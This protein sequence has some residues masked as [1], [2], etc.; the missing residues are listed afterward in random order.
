[1]GWNSWNLLASQVN[2]QDLR[3]IADALVSSGMRDAGYQYLVIDDL[4]QTDR[5]SAGNLQADPQKFPQGIKAL[6]AYVHERGLK[7]G[8]YSDAGTKT[9][10]GA[11][12]SIDNEERDAAT[13]ASWDVDFLKYDYCY[14]PPERE[15][16]IE[17][18]TKMGQ[19]L[20][21]TGRPILFSICEWGERQPWEWGR[22]AHGQMW[23][24]TGDMGDFWSGS[25]HGFLR[26]IDTIGFS[27]HGLE[28]YA[29]PGGWNDP[30][31]LIV[32]LY[33][34]GAIGGG[35]CT[36]TEYRTH[37]GLWCLLAAPLMAG[38]DL[39]TMSASTREIL[40]NPEV[41]ALNQDPLGKQGF[42]VSQIEGR[43]VWKKPLQN[44]DL[45]V[46]LFN[47][48]E[49]TAVVTATWSDLGIEGRHAVRDLWAR[50][51]LE[52]ASTAF[53]AEVPAH[54]SVLLR[55]TKR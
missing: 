9:C 21:A 10:G 14:A 23:R 1:M 17:L 32:G 4:W 5:D 8:I 31:M 33:G 29:G 26:G 24:T 6:A 50:Q 35:G 53:S 28:S 25:E 11:P 15:R 12:G 39:R 38:C 47:R 13:F 19:A 48:G 44:G 49:A 37:M 41:L 51:D 22:A 7:L 3:A 36:E 2:E 40:T 43:E 30:D 34:Q 27:Q 16:A 55:I 46:G 52:D 18:Y 54:G 20:Q 45:G 42:R